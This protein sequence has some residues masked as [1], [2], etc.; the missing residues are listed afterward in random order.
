MRKPSSPARATRLAMATL[1]TLVGALILIFRQ[2]FALIVFRDPAHLTPIFIAA[3]PLLLVG[4][5]MFLYLYLRGDIGFPFL[6]RIIEVDPDSKVLNRDAEMQLSEMRSDIMSLREHLQRKPSLLDQLSQKERDAFV[7][8][9]KDQ[10]QG[11]VAEDIVQKIE[12]KYSTKIAEDAHINQIR[13]DINQSKGRLAEEVRSL[14]RRNSLNLSIGAVTTGLAVAMLAYLVLGA[15]KQTFSNVPDLLAHFIP[16]VS[17]A[18]FIQVFSFFFLKLYKTGLQE[19]KYFQN[20]L[21]NIEMKG[22]AIEA[23]LLTGYPTATDKII[24]QLVN[25]DRNVR[26]LTTMNST[27]SDSSDLNPKD[28]VDLLER[29][30][31]LLGSR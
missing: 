26:V 22:L 17:I 2:D 4:I 11:V 9:L 10:L 6:E 5:G 28:L 25:V 12:L 1:Y 8:E 27:E 31:K 14:S 24:P 3:I 18:A 23:S 13:R 7:G 21:T 29:F 19:I 15:N 20:E 16:R 30:G